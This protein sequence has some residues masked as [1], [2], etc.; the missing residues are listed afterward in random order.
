MTG[1][2]SLYD[3]DMQWLRSKQSPLQR[4]MGQNT[5]GV[6]RHD[7]DSYKNACEMELEQKSY[8]PWE[9]ETDACKSEPYV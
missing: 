5:Y 6:S 9:Q 1:L 4:Q 2:V 8:K 7:V 3:M